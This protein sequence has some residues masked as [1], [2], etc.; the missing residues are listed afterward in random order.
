MRLDSSSVIDRIVIPSDFM[1]NGDGINDLLR[2]IVTPEGTSKTYEGEIFSATDSGKC[3]TNSH[4]CVFESTIYSQ[5]DPVG[6]SGGIKRI[7]KTFRDMYSTFNL[8][9]T[10]HSF[11][12]FLVPRKTPFLPI[13][14]Y[15]KLN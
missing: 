12:I 14:L 13:H 6:L 8:L 15:K 2:P 4:E 10:I 1:P 9:F 3:Y 11:L 7:L 5:P